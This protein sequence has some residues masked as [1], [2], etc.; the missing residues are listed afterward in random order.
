MSSINWK[1]NKNQRYGNQ[2]FKKLNEFEKE[3]PK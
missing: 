2:I 1:E 3:L